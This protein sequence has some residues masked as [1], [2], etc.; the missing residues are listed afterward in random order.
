MNV[1][2][3]L[4]KTRKPHKCWGCGDNL[5]VGQLATSCTSFEDGVMTTYW[6]YVCDSYWKEHMD[7]SDGINEGDLK[8]EQ[9]YKE[10]RVEFLDKKL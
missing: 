6:C 8:Y 10:F 9:H 2:S 5:P 1:I 4:V 3:K 7:D